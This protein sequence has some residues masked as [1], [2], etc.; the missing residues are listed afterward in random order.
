MPFR[1]IT[2]FFRSVLVFSMFLSTK[3]IL[4][5]PLGTPFSSIEKFAPGLS[6]EEK[7]ISGQLHSIFLLSFYFNYFLK[8][9]FGLISTRFVFRTFRILSYASCKSL[10]LV[11]T[12]EKRRSYHP[13]TI[14]PQS[15]PGFYWNILLVIKSESYPSFVLLVERSIPFFLLKDT[16]AS[17]H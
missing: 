4:G 11:P 1:R 3:L 12:L 10:S 9:W 5:P 15:A 16:E 14:A 8:T 13:I 17:K 7:S 6:L 2:G